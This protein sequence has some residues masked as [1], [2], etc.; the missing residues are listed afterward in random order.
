MRARSGQT[1]TNRWVSAARRRE[2]TL[3]AVCPN[4]AAVTRAAIE[5]A[6]EGDFP[7][8]L[9]ATLN[10]VDLDGG[11]TGWTPADL[12]RFVGDVIESR[13]L[14]VDVALCLDHGGQ[15]QKDLHAIDRWSFERATIAVR[16]S[17]EACIDAGYELLHIDPT[18]SE[19]GQPLSA[20]TIIERTVDLIAHAEA[21]RRRRNS[22]AI[23]YEVGPDEYHSGL[24]SV[25]H[26]SRYL[27][28][29]RAA[30]AGAGLGEI[31]PTFVVGRLG[32]ELHTD[33]VDSEAGR[34]MVEL[35]NEEGAFIKG[36]YTD[37]VANPAL[38]RSMGV[39]AANI[40]PELTQVEYEALEDVE[41]EASSMGAGT[42]LMTEIR[43]AVEG[44][45]RWRKWV[46]PRVSQLDDVPG[47]HREWLIK[48]GARYVWTH[49]SVVAARRDLMDRSAGTI[50][51]EAHVESRIRHRILH[52]ARAFNLIG[53]RSETRYQAATEC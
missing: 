52:Y 3:L 19:D 44:S 16:N 6:A 26:L 20:E 34:R 33:F 27:D 50:N 31:W 17:I 15:F 53:L 41:R 39:G 28:L 49:P 42:G 11:Y 32:T 8:M 47:A 23:A 12:S 22:G 25:D 30:L 35:V 21:Y 40:G 10:Q 4:S 48:T 38:Y 51:G 45:G 5:A 7:L 18:M 1:R 43:R 29:L 14:D 9:A 46:D 13:R 36:H 2:A 24:T 37:Y